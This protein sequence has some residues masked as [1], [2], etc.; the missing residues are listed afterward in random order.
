[1]EQCL[2]AIIGHD[3]DVVKVAC[4]RALQY[5][6]QSIPPEVTLPLQA[7]I[8]SALSTYL[9]SVNLDDLEGDDLLVTLVETLRDVVLLDTRI[10]L[11]DRALDLLFTIASRGANNFQITLLA[12]ET[13]QEITTTISALGSDFY[14]QLCTKVL[15]SLS[16]AFDVGNLTEENALTN[17]SA[18][19]PQLVRV[20]LTG[21]LPAGR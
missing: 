16:G 20:V 11:S 5:Y 4:I 19:S 8:I 9:S 17:V 7:P 21:V 10:C 18:R 6:L 3:S 15:P 13:F 2:H 12:N 1:M 14:V